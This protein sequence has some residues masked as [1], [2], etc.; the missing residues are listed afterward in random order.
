[1]SQIDNNLL[2]GGSSMLL[3]EVLQSVDRRIFRRVFLAGACLDALNNMIGVDIVEKR[4]GDASIGV[5]KVERGHDD[6]VRGAHPLV[7]GPSAH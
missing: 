6:S 7:V 5:V 4:H 3:H 1:M 2:L